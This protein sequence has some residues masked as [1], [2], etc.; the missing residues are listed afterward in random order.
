M[1]VIIVFD[2]HQ[3]FSFFLQKNK[4]EKRKNLKRKFLLYHRRKEA[5]SHLPNRRKK[6][7]I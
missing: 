4:M 7:K 1:N 5:I 2:S 3:L 6:L